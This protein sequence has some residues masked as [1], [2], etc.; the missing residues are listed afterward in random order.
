MSTPLETVQRTSGRLD[1]RRILVTGAASGMGRAIAEL[2]AAEGARLALFDMQAEPLAV[3]A[4]ATGGRAITV[5]V[6]DE[7][8]VNAAVQQAAK[9]MGGIDGIVNA[10]GVLRALPLE[11]TEPAVWRRIHDVN[12]FGPYLICNAALPAMRAAGD[13]TIV[14]IAS[15][16]GINTPNQMAAYG[17]SKAGLIALTKG[18]A[19]EWAPQIRANALCPGIIKTPMTDALWSSP[20]SDEGASSVRANVG[21]GRKGTPMEIAYLALFLTSRESAFVNGSVYTIDGGPGRG[22]A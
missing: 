15:M 22:E 5:D 21:L 11:Q 13:A 8:Q 10:A 9:A 7:A 18:Q 14:N 1:G 17:A 16:G 20:G 19:L 3:I 2:F 6:S 4:A 12:L